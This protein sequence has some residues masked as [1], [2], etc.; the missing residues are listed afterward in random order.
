MDNTQYFNELQ[1]LKDGQLQPFVDWAEKNAVPWIRSEM[2]GILGKPGTPL[3]DT[4]A[5]RGGLTTSYKELVTMPQNA[6]FYLA[7]T[8]MFEQEIDRYLKSAQAFLNNQG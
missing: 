2:D 6:R 3:S 7:H 5:V 8:T 4:D 1:T